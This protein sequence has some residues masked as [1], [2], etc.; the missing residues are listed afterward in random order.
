MTAE[1]KREGIESAWVKVRELINSCERRNGGE[2]QVALGRECGVSQATISRLADRQPTKWGR[3]FI[4]LYEYAN[5][6]Q[7]ARRAHDPA[8]NLLLLSALQDV[9][10]GTDEHAEA[11]AAIIRATS[12][13]A[14][15]AKL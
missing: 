1:I 10:N 15:V 3:G 4:R 13:L 14:R 7:I 8:A 6:R 9:W 5:R 12:D 11:L 2:G